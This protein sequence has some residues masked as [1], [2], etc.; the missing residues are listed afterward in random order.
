MDEAQR[1]CD[2]IVLIDGGR[3]LARAAPRELIDRHV[4]GHVV[5][6]REAGA[7]RL[8]ANGLA[9]EDIGDA[10]LFYVARRAR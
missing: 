5:E 6:V 8:T 9:H 7:A 1:L 2:R 10:V 3:I 4:Q